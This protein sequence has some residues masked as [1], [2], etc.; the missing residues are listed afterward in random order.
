MKNKPSKSDIYDNRYFY[1][2]K[3][4]KES[5]SLRR[6]KSIVVTGHHK[7]PISTENKIDQPLIQFVGQ[8][9]QTNI[10]NQPTNI[11]EKYRGCTWGIG[12]KSLLGGVSFGTVGYTLAL[13]TSNTSLS[14][15]VPPVVVLLVSGGFGL[16]TGALV[17]L[18]QHQP[19]ADAQ[20]QPLLSKPVQRV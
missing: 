7:K 12:A 15:G 4:D 2:F 17:G 6:A 20:Q 5:I 18:C 9:E 11:D 19:E 8:P 3:N 16:F 10:R 13:M 14:L 1:K